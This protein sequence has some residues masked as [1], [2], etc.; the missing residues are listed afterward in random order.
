MLSTPLLLAALIG[1]ASVPVRV[2]EEEFDRY[3]EHPE[4]FS[5]NS[6]IEE[7]PGSL[8]G[9]KLKAECRDGVLHCKVRL[10]AG[11]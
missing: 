1:A 5:E 4:I 10:K 3:A 6:H 8:N 11:D 9:K 7:A 2:F